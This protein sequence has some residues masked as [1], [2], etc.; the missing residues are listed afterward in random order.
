MDGPSLHAQML[1]E[2]PQANRH[3]LVPLIGRN[4]MREE[5]RALLLLK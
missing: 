3:L 1:M 4:S 2:R 5:T